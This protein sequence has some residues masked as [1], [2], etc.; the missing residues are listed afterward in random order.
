[1]RLIG[2]LT[3]EDSVNRFAAYLL[4]SGITTKVEPDGEKWLIWIHEEDQIDQAK[5]MLRHFQQYPE[6]ARYQTA[7]KGAAEIYKQR[8]KEEKEFQ[9][10]QRSADQVWNRPARQRIPLTFYLILTC[11]LVFVVTDM[12]GARPA[13]YV[14]KLKAA[15]FFQDFNRQ[16]VRDPYHEIRQGQLWRIVTPL[17]VHGN[18][19]HL[20][21]NMFALYTLAGIVEQ[22]GNWKILAGVLFLSG[23]IPNLVIPLIPITWGGTPYG[24]GISGSIFGL[25]GF[26]WAV[27]KI[28]PRSPYPFQM[29]WFYMAIG[30]LV[31]GILVPNLNLD[32]WGHGLGLLI[33]IGVAY[34]SKF[35]K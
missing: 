2:T 1:M 26:M 13:P 7:Q 10:K 22:H 29:Q 9:K 12:L 14:S 30:I 33:G 28:N 27:Q 35:A 3:A 15:L 23:A 21:F 17:F 6:D 25:I 32:N 20:V 5:E 4:V 11:S 31:F 16:K 24:I 18:L 8:E 34:L 19:W